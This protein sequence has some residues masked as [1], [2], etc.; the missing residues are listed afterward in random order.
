M[1]L[2]AAAELLEFDRHAIL[3]GEFWRLWTCHLMHYSLQHALLD[4]ATA[5]AAGVIAAQ[6]LG[7]RRVCVCVGWAAP[8]IAI[9]LLLFAP[10]CLSYRGA[11]GL[12]VMLVALAAATLWPRAGAGARAA[13]ALL[14]LSL[15]VKI[16]VEASGHAAPWA[17]LPAD[18]RVAWPAHLLGA[19]AGVACH[20]INAPRG[21][22]R[23]N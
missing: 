19:C 2:D 20:L 14:G 4:F 18:V 17:G 23:R 12:A 21:A 6:M 3:A 15:L 1:R 9:G 8:L 5:L 7:W 10:D 11:S 16:A 22:V 13:L